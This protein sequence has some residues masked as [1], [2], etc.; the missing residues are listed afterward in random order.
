MVSPKDK[1]KIE[2]DYLK[3]SLGWQESNLKIVDKKT[4]LV[5]LK[6]NIAQLK[7]YNSKMIQRKRGFPVRIITLKARQEGVSTGEAADTF[8]DVNRRKNR[9][10]CLISADTDSTDKV[11]KMVRRFQQYMPRNLKIPTE[12]SNRKEITYKHPH[13][14][15]ILC[16][17]AGKDVL[18]RGG[19]THRVHATELAF[20]NNAA[21]QLSGLLQ[22][23]PSSPE[24][25]VHIE[26][27]A[28]GTTGEF[29]DRYMNAIKRRRARP[30]DYNCELPIFLPWFIFPEYRMAIPPEYHFSPY[31]DH[32][33]YGDEVYL[34]KNFNCTTE[35]LYW[36]RWKIDNDFGCFL[37]RFM[38]EYPAT[39]REAFQGTGRMVF[40]PSSIDGLEEHCRDNEGKPK[41]AIAYVEFEKV[42]GQI[43]SR[44]VNK[45][46]NCWAIWRWPEPYNRYA[47]F[48]DPAEGILA[49]RSNP[50]SE[51]D[52]SVAGV[53]ERDNLVLV[54]TYYGRPGTIEFGDQM[55][56][57]SI[58]Y[59]YAWSSPE[60]N[61]IGQSVLDT[62]KRASYS[63]I[64]S[65]KHHEEQL[66]TEDSSMLGWKTTTKTRKP[67]IAD[68]D[69]V[70][71]EG[72]LIVHDIRFVDELRKF[73]YGPDGKPQAD[74]NYH[75][76]CVFALAGCIQLHKL[77]P[78]GGTD[79]SL[80]QDRH[81]GGSSMDDNHICL[82]NA[83]DDFSDMYEK[84]NYDECLTG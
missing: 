64:F 77:C 76:D 73:V 20:W 79:F 48:G 42:D 24:T 13:C 17:T 12:Y 10:A 54:A 37:S 14:S 53:L 62:Y 27:T 47:N 32:E 71:R 44:N 75:D 56:Y 81:D 69:Q 60:I 52:R 66:V 9:M 5:S 72:E 82:P 45:R 57:A 40:L 11:F 78:M 55:L 70:L 50:R 25:E 19:T 38:Q 23:V 33:T 35:Q 31:S 58:F 34:I 63:K 15:S 41:K 80:W 68:L 28:F 74:N 2:N 39:V 59:N 1:A 21:D 6:H 65:R 51:P 4:N 22:E 61:S 49:E 43:I 26:S 29:H 8:E 30:D 84:D 67:M 7:V 36:R 3:T 46:E 16:Q 83:V 18:G